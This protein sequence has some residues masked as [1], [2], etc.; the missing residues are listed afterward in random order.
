V[1]IF[2]SGR[3]SQREALR[4]VRDALKPLG[5]EVTSRWIDKDSDDKSERERLL[6]PVAEQNAIDN[7]EDIA[8]S[9]CVVSFTQG[10]GGKKGGRHVEFGVAVALNKW[11]VLIGTPENAFHWLPNIERYDSLEEWLD[12]LETETE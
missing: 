11:C 1:K 10:K 2:L 6:Q 9:D 4:E 8:K 5:H 3:W 7:L 12:S